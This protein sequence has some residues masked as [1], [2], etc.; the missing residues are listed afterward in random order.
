MAFL[1]AM[2]AHEICE[3]TFNPAPDGSQLNDVVT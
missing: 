2:R 3:V 1:L